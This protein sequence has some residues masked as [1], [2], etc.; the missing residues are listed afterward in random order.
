MV[1]HFIREYGSV[2]YYR[3]RMR[4]NRSVL[5]VENSVTN[6]EKSEPER[7]GNKINPSNLTLRPLDDKTSW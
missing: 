4:T 7:C 2:H 6:S 1:G 3:L 5:W